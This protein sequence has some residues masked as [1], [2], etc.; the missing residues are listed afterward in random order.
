VEVGAESRLGVSDLVLGAR[1]TNLKWLRSP[2]DTVYFN[3]TGGQRVDTPL[4]LFYEVLGVP[5]GE[6]YRTEIKVS[7]P[8]GLGPVAKLFGGGGAA[9]TIRH[10][11]VAGGTRIPIQ[12]TL[13]IGRLRPGSYILEVTAEHGGQRV[14]RRA[15]FQVLGAPSP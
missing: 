12:Q 4:E 8:G 2:E 7:R 14:R 3:P 1:S 15:T 6:R 9:I 10:E 11:E 13:D 5:E